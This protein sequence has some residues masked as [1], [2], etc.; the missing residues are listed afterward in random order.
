MIDA[1]Q[2]TPQAAALDGL[3]QRWRDRLIK[4]ATAMGV[5]SEHDV[6]WL[7]VRSYI[8]S[9]SAAAAAGRFAKATETAIARIPDA[10]LASVTQGGADLKASIAGEIHAQAESMAKSVATEMEK[11][12]RS[13]A[14]ALRAAADGLLRRANDESTA[15]IGTWQQQLAEAAHKQGSITLLRLLTKNMIILV[16]FASIFFAVGSYSAIE[17]LHGQHKIAP[18]GATVFFRGGEIFNNRAAVWYACQSA[19]PGCVKTG[20]NGKTFGAWLAA[21][22]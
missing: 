1:T 11:A 9:W 5:V 18:P 2:K 4:D 7:M 6:A 16:F 21:Q 20:G 15:I 8:N 10:V 14:V 19:E 22:I 17:F 12:V 13:G 3:P